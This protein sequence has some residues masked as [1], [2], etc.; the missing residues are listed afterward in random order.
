MALRTRAWHCFKLRD[1]SL[2]GWHSCLPLQSTAANSSTDQSQLLFSTLQPQRQQDLSKTQRSTKMSSEAKTGPNTLTKRP[3]TP[4]K[5]S[6]LPREADNTVPPLPDIHNPKNR[7]KEDKNK[8]NQAPRRSSLG[9]LRR[10]KSSDPNRNRPPIPAAPPVLPDLFGGAGA[11]RPSQ[12]FGDNV[13][14]R[15]SVAIVSGKLGGLNVPSQSAYSARKSADTGRGTTATS[16]QESI[17]NMAGSMA[18]R[19]RYS[20]A[21]TAV[22][23]VNSPRRVRRRRDPTPFKYAH[24]QV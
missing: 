10:S 9:F 7:D 3:T 21:S 4:R 19:G 13:D 22:S 8:E 14:V 1:L 12:T 20:Y 17:E 11:S 15:D 2:A 6:N 23:A 5:S 16:Y 24:I 18:N